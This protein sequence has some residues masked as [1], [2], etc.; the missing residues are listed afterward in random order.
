MANGD[1]TQYTNG[2]GGPWWSK[3]LYSWGAPIAIIAALLYSGHISAQ[4]SR[5]DAKDRDRAWQSVVE[6][7]TVAME[8][9]AGVM[10]QVLDAV[11]ENNKLRQERR[12][13]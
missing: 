11:K 3:L 4:N 6:R 9:N 12:R 8:K 1:Q 10:G 5:E 7:N 2:N 13:P